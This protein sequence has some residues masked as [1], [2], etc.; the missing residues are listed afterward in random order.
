MHNEPLGK[1]QA[2]TQ[3]NRCLSEGSVI[4]SKHFR[5][6]LANDRLT[7][8][9]ILAVCKSGAIIMAPEK[10]IKSG[11]WKYRIEG[12]SPEGLKLALVFTFRPNMAVLITVFERTQ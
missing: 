7:T 3:L 4:Y 10:D 1:A 6:E 8:E 5:Q 9:D 11:N 2:K 12:L